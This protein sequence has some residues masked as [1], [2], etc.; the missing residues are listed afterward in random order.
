MKRSGQDRLVYVKDINRNIPTT[1]R[2]AHGDPEGDTEK[3]GV[4]ADTK[5]HWLTTGIKK[6]QARKDTGRLV[7]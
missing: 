7:R 1:W 3:E 6:Q 4:S 5:R 2:R